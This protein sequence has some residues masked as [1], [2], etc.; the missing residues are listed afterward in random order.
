MVQCTATQVNIE[1]TKTVQFRCTNNEEL[2]I[3]L[4]EKHSELAFRGNTYS[5]CTFSVT[6]EDV[7]NG[8]SSVTGDNI[9][10]NRVT[11]VLEGS[12]LDDDHFTITMDEEDFSPCSQYN[13]DEPSEL[14]YRSPLCLLTTYSVMTN[15]NTSLVFR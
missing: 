12:C 5:Q 14:N 4:G 13:E 15:N 6:I 1:G 8:T 2:S 3:T 7:T 9:S 11:G 10:G